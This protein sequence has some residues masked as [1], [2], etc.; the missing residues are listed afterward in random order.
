MLADNNFDMYVNYR[1]VM[2]NEETGSSFGSYA[3][4]DSQGTYETN[5]LN[6][7]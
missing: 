3:P 7:R 4:F 2:D 6:I 5:I 1:Y